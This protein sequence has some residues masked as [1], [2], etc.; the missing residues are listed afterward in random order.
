M[1]NQTYGVEIPVRPT[2]DA[3][4]TKIEASAVCLPFL[5]RVSFSHRALSVS[6]PFLLTLVL[7][8]SGLIEYGF[9]E[10]KPS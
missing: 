7:V 4:K 8:W 10:A 2:E 6:K 3:N 5:H 9:G 1:A